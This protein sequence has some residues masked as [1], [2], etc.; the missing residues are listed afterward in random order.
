MVGNR[1]TRRR[2]AKGGGKNRSL[3][4]W[5][6][7]LQS[8][9]GAGIR[10][11]A[12]ET[13]AWVISVTANASLIGLLWLLQ[14]PRSLPDRSAAMEVN[15]ESFVVVQ[16]SQ[17]PS[18]SEPKLP[19]FTLPPP[20]LG[21]VPPAAM[22]GSPSIPIFKVPDAPVPTAMSAGLRTGTGT[23]PA[24]ISTSGAGGQGTGKT[25]SGRSSGHRIGKLVIEEA[26]ALVIID[27]E[28]SSGMA[29][30]G[31][32]EYKKACQQAERLAAEFGTK[33]LRHQPRTDD[34]GFVKELV[35]KIYKERPEAIY[36]ISMEGGAIIRHP[37]ELEAALAENKIR[38][39]WTSWG[40]PCNGRLADRIAESGGHWD[41]QGPY[42]PGGKKYNK[43]RLW[44]LRKPCDLSYKHS[45]GKLPPGK[46]PMP[47]GPGGYPAI[48]PVF[49]EGEIVGYSNIPYGLPVTV[50]RETEE[51]VTLA[52]M[53]KEVTISKT[54]DILTVGSKGSFLVH[55]PNP[56]TE[57]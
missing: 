2:K 3:S 55:E 56:Y 22:A 8:N 35:A 19:S 46:S 30:L 21:G 52:L 51:E 36:W 37:E 48:V 17:A 5:Y 53:G 25:G 13:G 41:W 33:P 7:L 20:Q 44:G 49:L 57:N 29:E 14:F 43:C 9:L 45:G 50:I 10:A 54:T 31:A 42:A 39:Y 26:T 4:A 34:T 11:Y 47:C 24:Q 32:Q 23:S 15:L 18:A 38:I 6:A 28:S 1:K 16:P 40:L 27:A 12:T